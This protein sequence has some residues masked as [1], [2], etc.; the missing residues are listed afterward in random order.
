MLDQPE[1]HMQASKQILH[2]DY[3]N[4]AADIHEDHAV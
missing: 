1:P 3:I 4:S 2:P